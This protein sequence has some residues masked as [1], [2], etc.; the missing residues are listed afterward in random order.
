MIRTKQDLKDYLWADRIAL[1][2][3]KKPRPGLGDLK[4]KYEISLRYCEYYSNCGGAFFR[5]TIR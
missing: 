4:W 1:G 3:E 5:S 2:M